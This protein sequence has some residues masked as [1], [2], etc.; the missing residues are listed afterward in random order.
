MG[1]EKYADTVENASLPIRSKWAMNLKVAALR[2]LLESL[3]SSL[4]LPDEMNLAAF[5]HWTLV[6]NR[7]ECANGN[8]SPLP[9]IHFLVFCGGGQ[10]EKILM[11]VLRPPQYGW[12]GAPHLL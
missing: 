4:K 9:P 3:V 8:S 5:V 12:D 11:V 10:L 7:S 6:E 1:S 2:M